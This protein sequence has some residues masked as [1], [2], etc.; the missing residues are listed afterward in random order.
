MKCSGLFAL[1]LTVAAVL[2]AL[3]QEPSALP[4]FRETAVSRMKELTTLPEPE[5]RYHRDVP[6]FEDPTLD[7]S[8][9]HLVKVREP[10][11]NGARVLRR[12]I[13]IRQSVHGY[14][15]R[16]A[17]VDLDLRLE[18]QDS[19]IVTVFSNRSQVARTDEDLQQV[20]ANAVDT[21]LA[22]SQLRF[23]P[24]HV[25]PDPDLLRCE[26]LSARFLVEAYSDFPAERENKLD[27][28]VR[29]I[30]FAP[31]EKRDQAAFD[32]SLRKSQTALPKDLLNRHSVFDGRK[33]P[34]VRKGEPT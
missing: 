18:S 1:F 29:A 17:R 32:D 15:I 34:D 16:R 8:S 10:W 27:A 11:K 26:I 21:G 23:F 5:W 30:D 13:E 28:A 7:D 31:L 14:D 20:D 12:W 9:W 3:A 22:E 25:R 4:D 24:S 6:H 33:Q 2:M 19:M